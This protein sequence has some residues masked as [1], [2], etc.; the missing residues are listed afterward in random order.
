MAKK[1]KNTLFVQETLVSWKKIDEQNYI[2]LTDMARKFNER[3][4]VPIQSWMK[5][6]STMKFLELWERLHNANFKHY[7]MAVIREELAD[8]GRFISAQKWI[9][10]TGAVGIISKRGR[11]GGTYGHE[12]IAFEFASWLSAEFKLYLIMEFKRLKQ[13][14][15]ERKELEWNVQRFIT[16]RNY[17]LQQEA[18][19]QVLLP[20]SSYENDE[21]WLEYASE[22]DVLNR[23]LFGM[24]AK[25]WRDSHPEE[26]KQ[27]ENIRDYATNI[28][29]LVLSNLEAINSELIRDVLSKDERYLRLQ[30]AALFQL[31]IFYRDQQLIDKKLKS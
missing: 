12:D 21:Q 7:Q 5:N 1:K 28:Q 11:Y 10:R 30:E 4:E 25:Q 22:A 26:V 24:T 23:A 15:A 27:G 29:L 17:A 20:Q 2:S 3:P 14:E 19:K 13:D 9:E 8:N 16:K 6:A 31:G 18:V